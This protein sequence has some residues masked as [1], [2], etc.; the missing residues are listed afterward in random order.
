LFSN[1]PYVSKYETDLVRAM[2]KGKHALI[3]IGVMETRCISIALDK[4][5]V[6]GVTNSLDE[7]LLAVC[8]VIPAQMLGFFKSIK[9]GLR[10]DSPSESGAISRVVQGVTIYPL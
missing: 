7:D 9:L 4:E 8:T 3:E 1:K 6:L 2:K 10:P 5:I